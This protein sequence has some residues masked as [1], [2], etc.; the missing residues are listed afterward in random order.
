VIHERVPLKRRKKDDAG[1]QNINSRTKNHVRP[2]RG[3]EQNGAPIE[4]VL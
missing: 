4:A 1:T 3:H 2:R